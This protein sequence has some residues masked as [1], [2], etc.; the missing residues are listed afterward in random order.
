MTLKAPQFWRQE[1]LLSLLLSPLGWLYGQIVA[2]RLRGAKNKVRVPVICVGNLTLGGS[3]K[4]PTVIALAQE[5]Q[6]LGHTPHVLSRGYGG[7]SYQALKVDTGHH[8]AAEVGDEAF[9]LAE[10]APTWVGANRYRS[11]QAAIN[12]GATMLIMD[13]G[14]QNP[15]LH[16]D[17]KIAVF[18]GQI[19][20]INKKIFPAGPL[21][22]DF[23]KGLQ[24]ID[25]LLL[26]NFTGCPV[27]AGQ[28]PY[29]LAT[30]ISEQIPTQDRYLA[31]AG[32]GY[33]EKF[34]K[35]LEKKGFNI[36][37]T[38]SFADHHPYSLEDIN[39]LTQ[40]AK[41]MKAQL[42]TTEKDLV[43]I[44][45]SAKKNIQPL[46]IRLEADLTEIVN[47]VLKFF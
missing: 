31:F 4:T 10:I 35:L 36:I 7:K 27:W 14:L 40:K 38:Y 17:F 15:T 19:P 6:R 18:D 25:H 22:E 30:T 29:T 21:R 9:L 2:W 34:F 32:I 5:F 45:K 11:A 8:T 3:G 37:E 26:L 23:S 47:K 1:G 28:L 33:P 12:A 43:K 20:L 44:P 41:K 24:R 13:D 16:Q 42:I 39:K 46:K